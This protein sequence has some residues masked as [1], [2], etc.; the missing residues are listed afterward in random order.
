MSAYKLWN[1]K[2]PGEAFCALMILQCAPKVLIVLP[3]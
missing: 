1:T 2:G 3:D